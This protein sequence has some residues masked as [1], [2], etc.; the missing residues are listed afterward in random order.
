[1]KGV[2]LS[3]IGK[4]GFITGRL[5]LTK[6]GKALKFFDVVP[7]ELKLDVPT[8]VAEAHPELV[9]ALKANAEVNRQL[10]EGMGGLENRLAAI[11]KTLTDI[12]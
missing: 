5:E 4:W 1:M 11:E 7:F 9:D 2:H 12:P 8:I 10:L 6:D 3:M